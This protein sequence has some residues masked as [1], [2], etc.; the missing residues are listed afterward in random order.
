MNILVP[1]SWLRE[2]LKTKATS[3]QIAE[4][5]SLC[6]QSVEKT[7]KV[8]KDWIYEIEITTNRPDCLSVYGIARE[9]AA[10]LPRF[11]LKAKLKPLFI[12]NTSE[13]EKYEGERSLAIEVE[14][15]DSALCPRFTA[16]IFD[17]IQIGPS[18]KLIQE[19]LEKSGV[20]A[21]NNAIDISNYLMLELGQ[22]MHTFDYDKVGGAKMK[23]REARESE[24]I[25]TL[26]GVERILPEGAIVIEDG[27]GRI[28]DLCGIM[29][30]ENSA[31]DENTK[32]ALLFVQTYDPSR[33]RRTC[34][35]LSFRTEAA[36]RFEKGVD[37][38][39][40]MPALK[41][42]TLMFEKNCGARV[43][44]K[45]IDIYPNPPKPKK[46]I[47]SQ[48]ELNQLMGVKIKLAEAK[49]ILEPLGFQST[50]SNQQ[51][52]IISV[53]PHWRNDDINL[54]EDLIEEVARIYGYH[55]LPS[56][57]PT[58]DSPQPFRGNFKLE[59][60]VKDYFWGAGFSEIYTY[61]LQGKELITNAGFK[62][63]NCLRIINPLTSD[64]GYLRQ[65]LIPSALEVINL[66]QAHFEKIRIFEIANIYLK[67]QNLPDEK[68]ILIASQ[69]GEKSFWE[70]KGCF[71][72]LLELLRI[73][74]FEFLPLEHIEGS[75]LPG[76]TAQIKIRNE[77]VG[78][79]GEINSQILGNFGINQRVTI[80]NIPLEVLAKTATDFKTYSP[81]PKYPPIIEDLAF[82]VSP[83]T[84]VGP[85]LQLI[86]AAGGPTVQSI[87][88]LDSFDQTRTLRITYQHPEKT[89]TNEE[90]KELRDKIIATL[91]ARFQVRV[92]EAS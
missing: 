9:L 33:I 65:S 44:G 35:E 10:I 88:L 57:L 37:P 55:N 18:P 66:N 11:N 43:A 68:Q 79:L 32:R 73:K 80:L 64:L 36:S 27:E 21:L 70:L 31:V 60:K 29:G 83:Q 63:E 48:E 14:I 23:L 77:M 78:I 47:L 87:K 52:A 67:T 15:G 45:L 89:L 54:P 69:T 46:I 34:Q 16:L 91:S 5:L 90:V 40:V 39:G 75:W 13:Y 7:T 1:D 30:G 2:Y 25:I 76:R 42:A 20:R 19:R 8:G 84:Y 62:T 81:V 71:E 12:S 51:S 26:D 49:K 86:S 53:V 72:A 92:K 6:S 38:E 58:G 50:I 41:K 24:K 22:P 61:S 59:E 4:C 74:D 28:I 82:I 85:I 56:F 3:K 17:N